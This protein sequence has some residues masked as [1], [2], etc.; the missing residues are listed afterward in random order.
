MAKE[1]FRFSAQTVPFLVK[2]GK[3]K[4]SNWLDQHQGEFE[5][6]LRK[7]LIHLAQHLSNALRPLAPHYHFPLK[8]IGRL[9]RPAHRVAERGGSLYKNW[10]SYSASKPS[11]SRFEHNPSLFFLINSED[12]KDSIL[13]AG[14]LYM[15]SSR[16]VRAIR[17]AIAKDA[18]VFDE[19]FKSKAFARSFPDGFSDEKTAKRPPRGFDP[20]HSRMNWLKLQAFFVWRSY[21]R[22]EF[23]S[24]EFP[25]LVERDLKQALRLNEILEA[26]IKGQH[27]TLT[28]KSK[29]SQ[30]VLN[31]IE[32]LGSFE[33]KSDF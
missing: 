27:P 7:P 21:S 13:V 19:L 28:L 23:T 5:T 1:V 4:K 24:V 17:E 20:N 16:Q 18:K 3:Q 14:G 30:S 33:I 32:G 9:K 26:I 6:V 8:G 10:M 31:Q 25:K 2:A 22:K 12:P 15:A 11:E 29:S